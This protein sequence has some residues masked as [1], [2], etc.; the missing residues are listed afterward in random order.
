MLTSPKTKPE[1]PND[2]HLTYKT[3]KSFGFNVKPVWLCFPSVLLGLEVFSWYDLT[4]ASPPVCFTLS[5]ISARQT[6]Q[7]FK[8]TISW[9]C[10][11]GTRQ[12]YVQTMAEQNYLKAGICTQE[13]SFVHSSVLKL[14]VLP[15]FRASLCFWSSSLAVPHK[16]PSLIYQHCIQ[17]SCRP[18][19]LFHSCMKMPLRS[20]ATI[21]QLKQL[22]DSPIKCRGNT[23]KRPC[24]SHLATSLLIGTGGHLRLPPARRPIAV[25][26]HIGLAL[27]SI[28]RRFAPYRIRES[29]EA[30]FLCR[31]SHGK[32]CRPVLRTGLTNCHCFGEGAS[33]TGRAP[34]RRC[35][36]PSTEAD[37]GQNEL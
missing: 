2:L 35:N 23:K 12:T 22:A 30:Q 9:R 37:T 15:F 14:C 6:A 27:A 7:G 19:L 8:L 11:T 24:L 10:L 26:P 18:G 34:A 28:F 1:Q 16:I 5:G 4:C 25:W 13:A 20:H 17:V 29:R 33:N 21:S 3:N 36:P 31:D 32:F